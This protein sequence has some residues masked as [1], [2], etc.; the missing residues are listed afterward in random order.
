[1]LKAHPNT[2]LGEH[3]PTYLSNSNIYVSLPPLPSPSPASRPPIP[4]STRSKRASL[5]NMFTGSSSSGGKQGS[6]DP[7]HL[8]LAS[9]LASDQAKPLEKEV[10]R[11][12]L[13]KSSAEIALL[14]KASDL[15]S[16]GFIQVCL[17]PGFSQKWGGRR[18]SRMAL[19]RWLIWRGQVMKG[20]QP[21]M[22][23]SQLAAIFEYHC[24]M[25]G[26]ERQAYV[27]VVASG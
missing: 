16:E 11:L 19:L 2:S 21:G 9:S 27:P 26:S 17:S 3:L 24:A 5:I 1:M 13:K 6:H 4:P 8:M 14:K 12:R 10:Q 15:S 25:G 22:S 7:P 20:V 18:C 23:E